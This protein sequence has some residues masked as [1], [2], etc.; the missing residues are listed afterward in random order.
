MNKKKILS[1]AL[2][3]ALT[4][5]A[6]TAVTAV[7]ATADAVSISTQHSV[8]D[9][10]KY[11]L[12]KGNDGNVV[13]YCDWSIKEENNNKYMHFSK[14]STQASNWV[15]NWTFVLN[16]TGATQWMGHYRVEANARYRISFDYKLSS[17]DSGLG[18]T[19]Y[20]GASLIS[21]TKYTVGNVWYNGPDGQ[22]NNVTLN[23]C[24]TNQ[25]KINLEAAPDW[26]H[27]TV[28]F[29]GPSSVSGNSSLNF[30]LYGVISKN[31]EFS[32]DN[33]VLDRLASV[34]LTD[35]SGNSE[36][37]WGVPV[38]TNENR[39]YKTNGTAFTEY[40][41]EKIATVTTNDTTANVN[42]IFTDAART[43]Q[44]GS[45][46][47]FPAAEG[48]E[49]YT[50]ALVPEK[51]GV[52]ENTSTTNKY[53][54]GTNAFGTG[55]ADIK[56]YAA[57]SI[58]GASNIKSGFIIWTKKLLGENTLDISCVGTG[59]KAIK[60]ETTDTDS[61]ASLGDE[62][63][64]ILL[65]SDST[66]GKVSERYKNI[67]YAVRPYVSYEKDGNTYYVYGDTTYSK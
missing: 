41:G 63:Y 25:P 61:F 34:N 54:I 30:S 48:T 4:L 16:P 64:G 49:Y 8:I 55:F 9:F 1:L 19:W 6:V 15:P 42:A 47:V 5:S 56:A 38:A 58:S 32:I 65:C 24:D 23:R 26:K 39:L 3:L 67:N 37:V 20:M 60:I 2:T 57:N 31:V 14:T 35:E 18:S 13:D 46:A 12:S 52:Y 59:N 33:I 29:F 11:V 10:D 22:S 28:D 53:D 43:A 51:T 62:L 66:E 17:S 50:K 45:D 21:S 40:S 36:T 27:V 7:T 44:L